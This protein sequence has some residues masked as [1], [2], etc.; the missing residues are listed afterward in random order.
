VRSYALSKDTAPVMRGAL[1]AKP[2]QPHGPT[3]TLGNMRE[4]RTSTPTA[5]GSGWPFGSYISAQL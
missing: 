3:M 4:L 2:K 1:M 5:L